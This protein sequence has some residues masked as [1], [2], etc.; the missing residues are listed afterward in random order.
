MVVFPHG[1]PPMPPAPWVRHDPSTERPF[2]AK[3]MP[4]VRD[5]GR[6]RLDK[7]YL[8]ARK[9]KSIALGPG[10][11]LIFY[12]TIESIEEANR[13]TL[14]T[15]GALAGVP[16]MIVAAD[17]VFVVPVPSS[18][19]ATGFFQAASN[20]SIAANAR[21]DVVRKLADAPTGWNVVAVG[22]A[23]RPGLGL[24]AA[25]EQSAINDALA[26]CA[27][28]DRDCHVIAIGPF[29]VGAN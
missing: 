18:M 14:E 28:R 8:S 1:L 21:D 5:Q 24:K 23:G 20:A 26:D 7:N 4:M 3:D 19:K 9:S 22:T 27:K 13:R 15:C 11:Q 10:G 16:C 29:A 25:S 17:D 12:S 2:T 6:E